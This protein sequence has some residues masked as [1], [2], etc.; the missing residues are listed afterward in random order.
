MSQLKSL[1]YTLNTFFF[2]RIVSVILGTVVLF[3]LIYAADEFGGTSKLCHQRKMAAPVRE[4]GTSRPSL[5]T[6]RALF[7]LYEK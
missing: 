3:M 2:L 1:E 4:S 6:S 5:Y 7:N